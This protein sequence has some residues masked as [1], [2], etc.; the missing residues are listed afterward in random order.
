MTR[1]LRRLTAILAATTALGLSLASAG[2][3]PPAAQPAL[4]GVVPRTFTIDQ[5]DPRPVRVHGF[6]PP[7]P[8]PAPTVSPSIRATA[9]PLV[10]AR[11]IPP[12]AIAA[13]AVA[14]VNLDNGR[15]LWQWN[16]DQP[17]AP[18][19]L[20][21]IFTAMVASDLMGPNTLVTV[22]ASIAQL[23]ADSTVMGL[24]AGERV[25]VRDLLYGVLMVSGNDA[26]ETLALA[27]SS[28]STFVG[29]MNSKASRLGLRHTHFVN[30]T[31]LDAAGHYST[32][33]D[34]ARA[35]TY[36]EAHYPA[37]ATMGATPSITIEATTTHKRFTLVNLNKLL[38]TYPGT[39][40][41]KTGWTEAALGCLITTSSRGGRRLLAVVLGSPAVYHEMPKALDYGFELLGVL[42]RP[43]P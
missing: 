3:P 15:A 13:Q 31:G 16:G 19:S 5:P 17:R 26:A 7:S 10:A 29:Y 21:K 27:V 8:T 25:S 18:A 42:P 35:A 34:L 28:R 12:P 4:A 11:P 22:P 33:S 43:G 2:V 9:R 37:L 36:L 39:F 38:R 23:P 41:L 30:P 14:L 6:M 32:A 40:G 1:S 24:T 20:T